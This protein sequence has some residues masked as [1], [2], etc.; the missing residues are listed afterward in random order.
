MRITGLKIGVRLGLGFGL[1][2]LLLVLLAILGSGSM[3]RINGKLEQIVTLDYEKIKHANE[4]SRSINSL[5]SNMQLMM[6]KEHADRDRVMRAIE[7][8]RETYGQAIAA[9]A[10]LDISDQE[11]ILI[12]NLENAIAAAKKADNE[13]IGFSLGNRNDAAITHFN[14]VA[15]PLLEKIYLSLDALIKHEERNIEEQ[16]LA[17]ASLYGETRRLALIIAVIAL[18]LA[19]LTSYFVTRSIT[20]PL[21]SALEVSNRIASGDLTMTIAEHGSD[22]TGQLLAAMKRMTEKLKTVI[23]DVKNA[24]NSLAVGSEELSSSAEQT[25]QGATE[26]AAAAEEAS[27]SME[28]MAS[29]VK[30]NADNALET[31]AIARKSAV[32]AEEGGDAVARMVN[33]MKEIAG[34]I[35]IIEEIAR[36]TNLLALNAAIEAARAGEHGKGFAVVASEVRKLAERSQAAAAEI[37]NLSGTSLI[38]AD[39]AGEMLKKMVPDIQRTAELVQEITAASR[40]Q[41]MGANQ[42]N[43]AIQQ[44]DQVI[45]Q[46]ASISEHMASTAQELANQAEKLTASISFFTVGDDDAPLKARKRDFVS[47][48]PS[49]SW[50]VSD[51]YARGASNGY[52]AD[53]RYSFEHDAEVTGV[54]LDMGDSGDARDAE[55][56]RF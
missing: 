52:A 55:F 39:T 13:V 16:Y 29:N 6:L 44:L 31:E 35:S 53:N 32:N 41:D 51:R 4:V 43:K 49:N 46:N 40:E 10:K 12:A 34:K 15:S 21:N 7:D 27:S 25:S 5:I 20:R 38:V 45:Q 9:L 11:K 33:A 18:F 28:Q 36:Q 8:N 42:I 30:Q 47:S 17:A 3:G 48:R 14:T 50:R 56:E 23:G 26:Q 37:G 1:V 54:A 24:A 22:E 2:M 19:S